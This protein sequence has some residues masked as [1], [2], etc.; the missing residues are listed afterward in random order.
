MSNGMAMPA[1]FRALRADPAA[2]PVMRPDPE[3]RYNRFDLV[4]AR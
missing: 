1:W 2:L 4:L 3:A